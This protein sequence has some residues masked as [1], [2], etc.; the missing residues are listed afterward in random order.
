MRK[1]TV[2]KYRRQLDSKGSRAFVELAGVRH[3]LGPYGSSESRERYARIIAE[4]E[5]NGHQPAV[6]KDAITVMELCAHFWDFAQGYYRHQD[7][8]PT[9]ELANYRSTL[10]PLKELY[11]EIRALDFG[12]R[13]LKAIRENWIAIGLTRKHVNQLAGRIKRVFRWGVSEEL[14]SPTVYQALQAIPGL[15]RGRC[16]ARESQPVEPAPLEHV[17]AVKPYVSEEI[18]ALVQ[19]QLLTGARSGELVILRPRDIQMTGQVWTYTPSDHKTSYR[20]HSRTIY[21]GPKARE[22]L[23]PFLLRGAEAF[24]F[25]PKE[26]EE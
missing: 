20:E 14:I 8:S 13:A 10:K 15:K 25:S 19:L 22:I 2:P 1:K 5:S 9:R 3:Y 7:G 17:E 23:R 11:G 26:A 21:L 18:W 12:P 16:E 4:W 24:C 6:A